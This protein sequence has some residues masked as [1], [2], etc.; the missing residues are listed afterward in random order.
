MAGYAAEI[1]DEVWK[2]YQ[3]DHLPETRNKILLAYLYIVRCTAAKMHPVYRNYADMDDIISCGT[4][5]LMDA[6]ERFDIKKGV[7]FESF[8]SF[9]VRGS[10]IDYIRKQDW[11][12]R[13]LRKKARDVE[14]CNSRLRLKLGREPEDREVAGE[15]GITL[16]SLNEIIGEAQGFNLV[17][18]EELIQDRIGRSRE[19][20]A[21]YEMPESQIQEEELKKVI[22]A[23]IDALTEKERQ[24]ISLYYFEELKLKDIARV[25]EVSESRVSQIHSRALMKMKMAVQDYCIESNRAAS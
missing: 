7:K 8:A 20:T 1:D 12:P 16:Q 23:S 18:F 19:G 15:M 13:N 4:L 10:V 24:V 11:I 3:T 5:A 14:E 2:S 6:I 9:R 25:L 17:S 21:G 22:A